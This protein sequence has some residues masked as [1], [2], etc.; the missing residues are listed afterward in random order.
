VSVDASSL[1]K[2][3]QRLGFKGKPRPPSWST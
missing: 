3:P 2:L 1:Q